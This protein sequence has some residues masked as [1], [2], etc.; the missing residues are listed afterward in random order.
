MPSPT[1]EDLRADLDVAQAHF[2][3]GGTALKSGQLRKAEQEF[4]TVL[5]FKIPGDVAVAT[6]FSLGEIYTTL[7]RDAFNPEAPWKGKAVP[8][9]KKAFRY[10]AAML[11][12]ARRYPTSPNFPDYEDILKKGEIAWQGLG[13]YLEAVEAKK[14][15]IRKASK[16]TH[17]KPPPAPS[18]Q[19]TLNL[20]PDPP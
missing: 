7:C 1:K 16:K 11:N 4:E 5:D 10:Y 17:P 13:E 15:Q 8:H 12:L 18:P 20:Y 14:T 6:Y 19:L 9:A 3:Q 2:N